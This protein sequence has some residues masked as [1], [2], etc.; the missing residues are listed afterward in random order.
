METKFCAS[1]RIFGIGLDF[2]MISGTL[3]VQPSEIHHHGDRGILTP[4]SED[5]WRLDSPL[6]RTD[7]LD[8]H[9]NWL[10]HVLSP[11]YDFL[12]TLARRFTLSSYCGVGVD[13]NHCTFRISPAC[14][15]ICLELGIPLN[16]SIVMTGIPEPTTDALS[17]STGEKP[18]VGFD[19]YRQESSAALQIAGSCLEIRHISA[20]LTLTPSETCRPRRFHREVGGETPGWRFESGVPRSEELD[21]H[22]KRLASILLPHVDFLRSLRADAELL[23]SCDLITEND[24]GGVTISP[25][26]LTTLVELD[27]PLEFNVCLI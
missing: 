20:T 12:R 2:D 1:L 5:M 18:G 21:A 6:A 23:L 19:G 3:G 7:F 9:L 15:R 14:L 16:L 22:L 8:A 27:V 11:H 26:V 17:E 25:E 13:D 4:Y 24:H 10:R